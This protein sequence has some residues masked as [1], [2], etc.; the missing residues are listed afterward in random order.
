MMSDAPIGVFDSGVGGLTVL[1]EMVRQLPKERF[2]FFG[3]TARAPYGEKSPEV[4]IEYAREITR[5]LAQRGVKAVVTACNTESAY[6]LEEMREETDRPVLGVIKPGVRAALRTTQN[7]RIGVLATRAT[8]TSGAYRRRLQKYNS[9]VEVYPQIC[10]DF[11][12]HIEAGDTDSPE[13]YNLIREYLTPVQRADVDTVVLGCTHY[14]WIRDRI[15]DFFGERVRLIDPALNTALELKDI[16]ERNGLLREE[17][18]G[19]YRIV[20]SGPDEVM[21]QLAAKFLTA[22]TFEKAD[23]QTMGWTE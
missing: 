6:A 21:R 19:E 14:P 5:F 17:G 20:T 18:E 3:D 1:R 12:P 23:L 8:I 16:L 7:G 9:M 2:L 10:T 22:A 4:I 15:A 11:V 13:F